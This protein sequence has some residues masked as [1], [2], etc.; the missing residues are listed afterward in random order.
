MSH[1][2]RGHDPNAAKLY[3]LIKDVRFVMM[4]T[5]DDDGTLNSRPMYSHAA[6]KA[7]DLWFFTRLS[8]PKMAEIRHESQV[9][10]AYA[11]PSSQ[12]Y[13][14]VAGRAEIVRDKARIKEMWSEGVRVWFPK[15]PDDPDIALIRVHP[16]KG[17]Y[18]DSPSSTLV[19]LYGYAKARL[20][21]EP[22]TG[23][24]DAKKVD[25]QA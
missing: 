21:G 4:T 1:D 15:G 24:G 17:E 14:S 6:D 18:W 11:D 13:V 22:P 20:T 9:N 10:L 2:H 8:S 19:Y 7:G 3:D 12:T 5:L 25:L 23:I 16:E